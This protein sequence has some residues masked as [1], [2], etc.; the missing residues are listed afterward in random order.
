MLLR[1]QI[2]DSALAAGTAFEVARI[3]KK[4]SNCTHGARA[5]IAAELRPGQV[6]FGGRGLMH[7]VRIEEL[8]VGPATQA[9]LNTD[10]STEFGVKLSRELPAGAILVR[11]DG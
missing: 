2:V 3:V 6:Y 5:S 8:R 9:S 4:Y 10:I 7:E 1:S 11:L